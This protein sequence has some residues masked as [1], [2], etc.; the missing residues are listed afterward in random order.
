M[1]NSTPYKIITLKKQLALAI[2]Q[3]SYDLLAPEV[4]ALS[5]ALDALMNPLF[6][7]Q[8]AHKAM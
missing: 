6:E 7:A 3:N 1:E 5:Q 4:L 8:L 2:I